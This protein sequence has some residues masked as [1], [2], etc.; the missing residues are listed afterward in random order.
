MIVEKF[1]LLSGADAKC[2]K[3]NE[4]LVFLKSALPLLRNRIKKDGMA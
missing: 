1:A 3:E 2:G 4:V